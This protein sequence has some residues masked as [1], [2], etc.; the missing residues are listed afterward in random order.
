MILKG[1]E[2][3]RVQKTIEAI[4]STFEELIC[5]KE[6]EKITVKELCDRARIN[7]K[8]FYHYYPTLEDLLAELQMQMSQGYI[9]MVKDY[10]LP[11]ELDKVV[12]A[13]FEFSI[14]QGE[15]YDKIT[16]AG[17]Y[18]YVRQKMINNVY[19][20]TWKKSPQFNRLNSFYQSVIMDYLKV[21][22][23]GIYE[24]WVNDNK[25]MPQEELIRLAINLICNGINGI[26]S[27]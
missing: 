10:K 4:K 16:C 3:L 11:E 22:T 13:F 21:V 15:A 27:K 19:N 23:I 26:L 9:E 25:K 6:Y 2:D 5:E 1:N 14:R 18:N 12:Q 7:K 24:Q 20:A 8:T 17:S